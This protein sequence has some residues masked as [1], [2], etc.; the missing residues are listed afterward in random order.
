MRKVRHNLLNS[1]SLIFL[2]QL[3]K[4]SSERSSVKIFYPGMPMLLALMDRHITNDFCITCNH[5]LM[6]FTMLKVSLFFIP[7]FSKVRF[8]VMYLWRRAAFYM[9]YGSINRI[10][11]CGFNG[12]D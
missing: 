2:L 8:L 10:G 6:R 12:E 1:I 9:K 3:L 4:P 7:V 5:R 11:F